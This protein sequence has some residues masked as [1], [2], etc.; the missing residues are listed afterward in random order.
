MDMRARCPAS[1]RQQSQF[2]RRPRA[3]G[4]LGGIKK[5]AVADLKDWLANGDTRKPVSMR[6]R[7]AA[8]VRP[9][10]A[11]QKRPLMNY[12]AQRLGGI[13]PRGKAAEE[14]RH[15]GVNSRTAPGL[16]RRA[17]HK[18]L[19]NIPAADH[20]DLEALVGRSDDGIYLDPAR[21]I[22]AIV[23]EV[24][25]RPQPLGEQAVFQQQARAR[26][27]AADHARQQEADHVI[28]APADD[29]RPEDERRSGIEGAVDDFLAKY[30]PGALTESERADMIE[31]LIRDG[32]D[33][34]ALVIETVSRRPLDDD[35]RAE[36][37]R[38]G[39]IPFGDA[40]GSERSGAERSRKGGSEPAGDDPGRL[41]EEERGADGEGQRDGVTPA[42]ETGISAI[43]WLREKAKHDPAQDETITVTPEM[44]EED[45]IEPGG[46]RVRYSFFRGEIPYRMKVQLRGIPD[47][48]DF[49]LS[50]FIR[51]GNTRA[52]QDRL[53]YTKVERERVAASATEAGAEG[54]PQSVI[55][56][57]ER[58]DAQAAQA[59]TDR[60]RSEMQARQQQSKIRRAGGNAG[61]AG[62][63]FDTQNDLFSAAAPEATPKA[64][65]PAEVAASEYRAPQES[66]LSRDAGIAA[67]RNTSMS[68]ERRA[69]SDIRSYVEDV[70]GLYAAMSELAQTDQQKAVLNAE[71][72]RY[73]QGY[74]RHQNAMW[75]AQSRTASP[76]VTGPANFP[77]ASNRKRMETSDRR[78]AEFLEWREKARAAIRKAIAN[79]RP[80]EAKREAGWSAIEA[81]LARRIGRGTGNFST[82]LI[83][84]LIERLAA[85]G[86]VD[87][88]QRALDFLRGAQERFNLAKPVFTDRASVWGLGEV[89]QKVAARR[90]ERAAA[91]PGIIA[92]YDG[93][94]ITRVPADDRVRITFDSRVS[95][96][97][98]ADLK[99]EGWK[100][101]PR[102]SAWQRK[103]TNAAES[104]AKRIV[105]RHFEPA[106]VS[107]EKHQR[108][109]SEPVAMLTGDE[110][111]EWSDMLDLQRKARRWYRE[112][113]Q[114][115]SVINKETGWEIRFTRAASGKIGGKRLDYLLR[116]IPGLEGIVENAARVGEAEPDRYARDGMKAIHRFVAPVSV[117]GDQKQVHLVIREMQDGRK[118]YDLN[119]GADVSARTAEGSM[120]ARLGRAEPELQIG[121]D[122]L[123]LSLDWP[124]INP[125]PASALR[126]LAETVSTILRQHGLAGKVSPKLVRT[127]L[128][129][130]GVPVHGS[131]RAGEVRL[132]AG[133]ADP[134][135]T[136]RHEIIHAL[137]DSALWGR[138]YG[139]FTEA[140]WRALARAARGNSTLR[141]SVESAYPDLPTAGQT[142]EMVAE[143]YAD[144]ARDRDAVPPGPV[145]AALERIRSFF[146]AL[147]AALRG[148]GFI[149]AAR[150]MDRVASGEI[151]RRGSDGPGGGNAGDGIMYQ[152]RPLEL[153]TALIGGDL[154]TISGH[155]DYAAA[156]AGDVEAAVRLAQDIVTD[157]MV[158]QVRKLIGDARPVVVPV[159]S[160]EASGRNKIPRAGAEVLAH[161]LGL[162]AGTG[163]VQS[164]AP[165][166]TSLP[167]LDRIFASP[168]FDGPVI[169]GRDYLILDDTLTQGGTFAALAGH[170]EAGGGRVIGA[171][172]LTG[173]QY[174]AR[175]RPNDATLSA[176]REKHGDLE[177]DF[178]AATGHGFDALTESEARYLTN[179]K[180]ADA[181]RDRILAEG[182]RQ[183][184][185]E[186]Q[187]DDPAV[188]HQR[189]LTD[190]KARLSRSKGRALGMIGDLHWR[191][192][193][194]V[195]S[196]WLS[197][198]MTD[199]MG[200]DARW[201]VLGLVPGHALFTELGKGLPAAQEYLRLKHAM[202]AERNEWQ[203]RTAAKVDR[204]VSTARRSPKS[205][206]ALM[207]LMHE[208][209]M[210]GL[211]PTRP[212]GWKRPA[213]DEARRMLSGKPSPAQNEWARITL[214][215][216]EERRET[217]EALRGRFQALPKPFQEL[218]AEIRDTYSEM[219]DASES[220]LV[221]NLREAARVVVKNA[222]REHAKEL[223][224]IRDD[225]LAGK[226]RAE[227]IAEANAKK[228]RAHAMAAAGS[229][230][231]LKQLRQMFETNRLA[232]PYFPLARFGNY[233]VTIRDTD[234]KVTSFSRFE[235]EGDQKRWMRE[236][237]QQGLDR[238]E[239]G[240]LGGDV[241]LR[242]QVDPRFLADVEGLLM[243]AGAT[244]EMM[245]AVWQRW[246]ETLPDQS[247]RTS[248]IHRKNRLGFNQDAI[249]AFS[250]AMFH[251]AHQTARLRYG[252]QMEETLNEAEEQAK[253]A[254]DPN[255]AGFVVREM[256]QRHAF[257]MSPTNNLWVTRAT[258]MAF[259]WSLAANPAAAAINLTQT[260][261]VGVPLMSARYRKAGVSGVTRALA[262]ASHDFM[263]GQGKV[264]K[265]VKGVPVWTDTWSAEN[266][267]TL[268]GEERRAMQQGYE[269]GVIDKTQ[270]H[271]L[272]SV[273]DS[274]VEY[275]PA[276]E[277][278][279][280]VMSWGF[281]HAERF[282]RE[283]TYLAAYR[284]ARDEGLSHDASVSSAAA[285][286]WKTHFD[287]QNSSRP[288]AM[289]G[290]TAKVLTIFRSFQVN[291]LWRLFRDLHQAFHGS[292]AETRREA[293]AQ[294]IGVSL[295]MM[296]HAGFR[297]VWGYALVTGLLSLFFPDDDDMDA[298]LQDA[299]LIEGDSLGAAAWNWTMGLA[300]NGAP[301]HA[302]GIDLTNRIGMPE[303]WVRGDDR[304]REGQDLWHFYTDQLLGPAF[305][306]LGNFVMAGSM[307]DDGQYLRAFE[308]AAPAFLR[309]PAKAGRY[310]AGG[311]TTYQGD[312]LIEDVSPW[313]ILMQAQGFAPAEVA[314]RYRINSQLK[315]QE[316]E[317][318]DRR[319][320]IM[321]QI[322]DAIRKGDPIPERAIERLRGFNREYPEWA[323]TPDSIRQSV[324][325]RQRASAR[326]ELGV[327]L[328]PKL[329]DRL[330]AAQPPALY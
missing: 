236:A 201:N 78:T 237:E 313:Q 205:N 242:E 95:Q 294:L 162:E 89:A 68:P 271:D 36:E 204:W 327:G 69:D 123:N 12:V 86:D 49:A 284:L 107:G 133:S 170:I 234:G 158:Q 213:D 273:A 216:A 307:L 32:G 18:D 212:D 146:Q 71:I 63:L 130:S 184:I 153:E 210:L 8:A 37:S 312:P 140:E 116:A 248:R 235:K 58:S 214:N 26:E 224:R 57:A 244:R 74:I 257:T 149:D 232:G 157:D 295:S 59:E 138:P 318:S 194:Q 264:A 303:L 172:A 5:M 21:I 247:M 193:P 113:L 191:R 112:N 62:P 241:S 159:V 41:P 125:V 131:Y 132:S 319:R 33:I 22:E 102:N 35:L 120:D 61:D 225:G 10:P 73:R 152:R 19:D 161:R 79:A 202:D 265:R 114:G 314:E 185:G 251:G 14:L 31:N 195:F 98:A 276:R 220:A 129:R 287:V 134:V 85:N 238:V 48:T 277:R 227:A 240:V 292:D 302:L 67:Y 190:L 260:T 262:R 38:L 16:W 84:G 317:I 310:A 179:F 167:G 15:R 65:E 104:S 175:L 156:K 322:G 270:A 77:T 207:D 304:D 169:A 291:M 118:F 197:S 281:H 268:S 56:G 188:K 177:N 142:E 254:P 215:E 289:Q 64:H 206:Q 163:V 96:E 154:G 100:W 246:L 239:H 29:P 325:S 135:H 75:S 171:V 258:T 2:L 45:G 243:E 199:R 203:S 316:R 72:E 279:M 189:D 301:G 297:G 128:D 27:E 47:R 261:V 39:E 126:G 299:L 183:G 290:D 288:R 309:N 23:E 328:N 25:G 275:N 91:G 305:G 176:L 80:E 34:D 155:P 226:A 147:A 266:S 229:T 249:R 324:R 109:L 20:P 182:R 280:K 46:Y 136:A 121:A 173:K 141:R 40:D 250:S 54:K 267:A 166:R 1:R 168:E 228:T 145:R 221:D 272:A 252:T 282:N 144:W 286:T 160:E 81:D 196:D 137:R 52:T 51:F 300:L 24:A 117:G 50:E 308:K 315:N 7:R 330:R 192:T 88:V 9:A 66:D 329:N 53:E 187:G 83:K 94:E 321:R 119:L 223:Q 6:A 97:V 110:L 105:G 70:S 106:P 231:K 278:V 101:S 44:A 122:G 43:D 139:L 90:E 186:N 209:T 99:K 3:A 211:D 108:D 150:I 269:L 87:F 219:A 82:P 217:W 76:M 293:R 11:P 253:S 151:G 263:R 208:T 298:W 198:F 30:A 93:A 323:I 320:D 306:I 255:R 296:A 42:A 92:T 326:N 200:A 148:D 165:R 245:D 28:V 13:Y 124:K 180:P 174:S 218:Y 111:G 233:F 274:G 256:K 178:R 181:V 17:G 4:R 259:V 222:D 143:M 103:L 115:K 230:S 311:V 55:P 127:L 60:T 283:V 164:N 285:M